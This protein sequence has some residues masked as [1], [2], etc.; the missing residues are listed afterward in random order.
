MIFTPA[1]KLDAAVTLAARAGVVCK[2]APE[3]H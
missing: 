3:G 1:P 2:V